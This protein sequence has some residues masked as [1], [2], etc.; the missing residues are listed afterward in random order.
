MGK[1]R[2]AID[3]LRYAVNL[4]DQ[5]NESFNQSFKSPIDLIR[6]ADVCQRM[7]W[8]VYPDQLSERQIQEAIN[9]GTIPDFKE[10]PNGYLKAIYKEDKYIVAD[11]ET[12]FYDGVSKEEAIE[13]FDK[14]ISN[15]NTDVKFFLNDDIINL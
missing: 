7:D 10:L 8:D 2:N 1:N 4:Y 12:T 15:N 3:L 5:C 14:Q 13:V 11:T 9:F 6:L